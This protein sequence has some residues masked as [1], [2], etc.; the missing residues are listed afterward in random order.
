[1]KPKHTLCDAPNIVAVGGLLDLARAFPVVIVAF[2][3]GVQRI[4]HD[5]AGRDEVSVD[6]ELAAL[7]DGDV[8]EG[9]QQFGIRHLQRLGIVVVVIVVSKAA[10]E[11][12]VRMLVRRIGQAARAGLLGG[13]E[14]R[15]VAHRIIV[16]LGGSMPRLLNLSSQFL[17]SLG[18]SLGINHLN[19]L[20]LYIL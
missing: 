17:T 11:A 15:E 8:L 13:A 7:R 10:T 18:T 9:C 19:I 12:H 3:D 4:N 16:R 20:Y 1:M 14:F 2:A 5:R 6:V